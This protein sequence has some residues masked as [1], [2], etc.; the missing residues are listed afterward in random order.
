VAEALK[1]KYGNALL[2]MLLLRTVY[3][4]VMTLKSVEVEHLCL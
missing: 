2:R 3:V 1:E 4:Y